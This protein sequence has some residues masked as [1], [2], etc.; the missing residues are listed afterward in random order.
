VGAFTW[1]CF[2]SRQ[3]H[4]IAFARQDRPDNGH[5]AVTGEVAQDA[6]NLQVHFG[7][8]LLH[9]QDMATA[10]FDQAVAQAQETA[11]HADLILGTKRAVQQ[12]EGVQLLQPLAVGPASS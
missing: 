5:A 2:F 12:A 1:G 11:Q 3:G 8:G 9:A 4:R 7:Q 10:V 6:M